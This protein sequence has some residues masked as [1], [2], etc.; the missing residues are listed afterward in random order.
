MTQHI[1]PVDLSAVKQVLPQNLGK[2][3]LLPFTAENGLARF[4]FY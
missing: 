3:A 2:S 4:V 1:G